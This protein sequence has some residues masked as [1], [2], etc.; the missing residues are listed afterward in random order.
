MAR[1]ARATHLERML[2][3]PAPAAQRERGC[4]D[5]QWSDAP[6]FDMSDDEHQVRG[7][8][9]PVM[10]DAAPLML[11]LP[12]PLSCEAC[13]WWREAA[14]PVALSPPPGASPDRD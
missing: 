14:K 10:P 4:L 9:N 7:P 8:A 13:R 11:P 1:V 12:A 3:V 5:R 2:S 6:I